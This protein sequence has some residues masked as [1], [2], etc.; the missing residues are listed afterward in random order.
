M[1]MVLNGISRS[2]SA[3]LAAGGRGIDTAFLYGDA[4]QSAVGAAI[5]ASIVPREPS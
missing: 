3:W 1:P 2:H 5:A 4:Q